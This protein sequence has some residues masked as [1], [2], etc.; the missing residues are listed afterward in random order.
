MK[1]CWRKLDYNCLRRRQII[2]VPELIEIQIY[3]LIFQFGQQCVV[4]NFNLDGKYIYFKLEL[5]YRLFKFWVW[6]ESSYIWNF[7]FLRYWPN[8]GNEKW[9]LNIYFLLLVQFCLKIKIKWIHNG[10]MNWII[11]KGTHVWMNE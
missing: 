2:S 11:G 7:R 9:I 4:D 8:R 6:N 1:K 3:I 10:W 5:L